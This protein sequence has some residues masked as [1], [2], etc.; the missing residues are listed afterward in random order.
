MLNFVKI[1]SW[2]VAIKIL[3]EKVGNQNLT[4]RAETESWQERGIIPKLSM[5]IASR[6]R[7]G[8]CGFERRMHSIFRSTSKLYRIPGIEA[9][10]YS[11][12]TQANLIDDGVWNSVLVL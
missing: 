4:I 11:L 2:G 7:I 10:V 9:A 8:H 12:L 6:P 5:R 1:R 3:L